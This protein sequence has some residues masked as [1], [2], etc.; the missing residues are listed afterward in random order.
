MHPTFDVPQPLALSGWLVATS[1]HASYPLN[2]EN[3]M[4]SAALRE[5]RSCDCAVSTTPDDEDGRRKADQFRDVL[6][7]H[8]GYLTFV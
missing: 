3:A 7:L 5:N 2:S 8:V 4:P 6:G 1:C